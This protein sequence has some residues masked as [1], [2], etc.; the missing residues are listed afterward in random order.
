[1]PEALDFIPQCFKNKRR[2]GGRKKGGRGG[3]KEGGKKKEQFTVMSV[4]GS[5]RQ[6][7][8]NSRSF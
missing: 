7:V 3:E 5:R 6:R 1:M 8:K 4:L 2:K